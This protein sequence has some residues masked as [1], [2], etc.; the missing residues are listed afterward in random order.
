MQVRRRI[1]FLEGPRVQSL[2]TQPSSA[3]V[4]PV[5]APET[6][7]VCGLTVLFSF[8]LCFRFQIDNVSSSQSRFPGPAVLD[9]EAKS[10]T[11]AFDENF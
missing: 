5:S 2:S 4:S 9:Y 7:S 10:E 8:V 1:C 6:T 11:L 3:P